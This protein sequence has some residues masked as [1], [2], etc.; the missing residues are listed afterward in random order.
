M[1]EGRIDLSTEEAKRIDV[2]EQKHGRGSL[3][4]RDPGE[5]GPVLFKARTG[6][7]YEVTDETFS[8]VRDAVEHG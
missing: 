3:S 6:E 2:L 4:R 1:Q 7:I 5:T 8:M